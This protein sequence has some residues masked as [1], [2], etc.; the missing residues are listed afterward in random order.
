MRD[1]YLAQTI[2]LYQ[3]LEEQLAKFSRYGNIIENT[4]LIISVI[5]SGGL[6]L[7]AA[8]VLPQA[9]TWAGAALSTL[10]TS[11]TLYLNSSG[12][13]K[14]RKKAIEL[15]SEVSIFLARIRSNPNMTDSEFWDT[16]KPLQHKVRTLGFERE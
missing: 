15:H 8:Q 16:Y 10:T 9:T 4:I 5:T 14:K 13:N 12:V 3:S 6:W 2:P 1:Y 11:L 7:L